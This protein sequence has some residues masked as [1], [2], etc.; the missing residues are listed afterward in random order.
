MP[1]HNY[2]TDESNVVHLSQALYIGYD[3]SLSAA[4]H[5]HL[6]LSAR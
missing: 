3:L 4:N 6:G 2:V 1:G 5:L